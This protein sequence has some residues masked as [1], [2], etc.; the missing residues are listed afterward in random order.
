MRPHHSTLL[1]ALAFICH[2]CTGAGVRP[3]TL[4]PSA[5][6]RSG[7]GAPTIEELANLTYAGLDERLGP[8]TLSNGRWEGAPAAPGAA[9]GPVVQL[10]DRFRVN[11]DLDGGDGEDTVVALAY[12]TGGSGGFTFLALVT[13]T[14]GTLR[15]AAT[16]AMGDRVQI[17]SAGVDRG[18]LLVSAIRAGAQDAA[19]C[20]GELVDLAWTFSD[21]QFA[22]AAPVVTGRLSP[23]TLGRSVWVL[24]DWDLDM[25]APAEPAVTLASDA[26]RFSGSSG[27]NRYTAFVATGATPGAVSVGP[28]AGT[29]MACPDP[30]SQVE[31]RFLRQLGGVQTIGFMLGRLAVGYARPDGT[32][33]TMLFTAQAAP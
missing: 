20:P 28:A 8:I 13:R 3:A 5:R 31:A 7:S 15:N 16:V 30:Q 12:S 22:P 4:S 27:C 18:R 23:N 17:R 19:C 9:S 2:A 10:L 24:R 33:G 14:S 6:T 1:A 29:R 32:R 25:P 11:G 26:G 21:G